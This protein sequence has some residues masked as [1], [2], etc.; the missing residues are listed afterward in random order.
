MYLKPRYPLPVWSSPGYIFPR[1]VFMDEDDWLLF[2][3]WMAKGMLNYKDL[4]DK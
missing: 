1:Q 4:I 2:T 3:G